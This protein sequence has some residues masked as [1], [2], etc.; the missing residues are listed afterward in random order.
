V[1]FLAG[2]GVNTD[3]REYFFLPP[4]ADLDRPEI[5]GISGTDLL[6]PLRPMAGRVLVFL[7]TCYG[8]ALF[9]QRTRSGPDMT[10]VLNEMLAANAG[11]VAFSAT[12]G[13]TRAEEREDLGNGV[14]THAL[15]RA[16]RGPGA[17]R[18]IRVTGL[19]DF[20]TEEV[21]RLTS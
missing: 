20:L 7:D 12:T 11:I 5:M 21:K 17:G 4:D 3:D 13:R 15:L 8:G 9:T 2:H 6:R 1:V 14:F 19:A 10:N 16:L 18:E